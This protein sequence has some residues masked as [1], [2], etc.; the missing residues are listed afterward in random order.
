MWIGERK[1]FCASLIVFVILFM[2]ISPV[3]AIDPIEFPSDLNVGPYVDT[4][5]YKVID[6]HTQ[7]LLSGQIEFGSEYPH[8]E[9]LVL[10]NEDPDISIFSTLRNG[11][12]NIL[13]NCGKYPLNLSAFRRA[14]AFA[15]DKTRVTTEIMGGL[16]Q[17]HDSIVPYTNSWCIEDVMPYHYY[18]AQVEIGNQILND[19]GFTIDPI[20]GYRFA[21]DGSEFKVIMEAEMVQIPAGVCQIGVDALRALHVNAE[22]RN[23]DFKLMLAR[24]NNHIDYDMVFYAPLFVGHEVDWLVS[25]FWSEFVDTPNKNP[26]NFQNDTFDSW[27]EQLL[28]NSSYEAV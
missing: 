3:L 16:S 6:D 11:Y 21:P 23:I 12:G 5:V 24:V 10:L 4:V 25:Q 19:A 22:M 15:F 14:F 20:T 17:E 8:A 26:T 28:Y 9:E 27:C 7:A 2:A 18:T 13:I 1:R